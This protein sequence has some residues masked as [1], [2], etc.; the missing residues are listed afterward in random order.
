MKLSDKVG[1]PQHVIA[2]QVGEESV[3]L[4]L[5]KGAYFGLDPVG[6]RVWQLLAEGMTLAQACDCLMEEYEVS[7]EDIE[8]DVIALAEHLAANG[9]IHSA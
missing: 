6:A 4:D 5:E 1:I 7:R 9:L 2:R 8:R 3:M